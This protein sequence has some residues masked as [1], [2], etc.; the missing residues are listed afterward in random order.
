MILPQLGENTDIMPLLRHNSGGTILCITY[1]LNVQPKNDPFI[2]AAEKGNDS[3]GNVIHPGAAYLVNHIEILKHVPAWLPGAK[4]KR[5]ANEWR[6]LTVDMVNKPFDAL[7]A[8]MARGT[9]TPSFAYNLLQKAANN[10]ADI[11][12]VSASLYQAG[13]ETTQILLGVCIL[14]LLSHPDKMKRIQDEIDSFTH[15]SRLPEFSD[16]DNV[17]YLKA[18]L[19]EALRFWCFVP[20]NDTH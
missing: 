15:G 17:P 10:E 12:N 6:K 4:F 19:K 9:A 20:I 13:A 14:S 1:G 18:F 8:E 5:D 7:K 11:R 2:E 16:E 3:V